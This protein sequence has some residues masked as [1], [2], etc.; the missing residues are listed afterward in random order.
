MKRR[1]V[2]YDEFAM[3]DHIERIKESAT[4]D[5]LRAKAGG[6]HG[7]AQPIF[8]VGMPRSGTTLIEQILAGHPRVKC[9][10]EIDDLRLVVDATRKSDGRP[11]PYPELLRILSPG[12]FGAI[13]AEY[14]RRLDRYAPGAD[15]IID[16]APA[17]FYLTG[18]IH[19]ALPQARIVHVTRSALDTCVSCFGKLFVGQW[20]QTY[21]L[22]ELG[23]YYRA[24]DGLMKHWR[25][26]LPA[27]A[28]LD[29]QYEAVVGD[30]EHEARRLLDYC[31]LE[32]DARVLN[33]HTREAAVTTGSAWQV[34]QPLYNAAIGRW[35]HYETH[36][37]P[38]IAELGGEQ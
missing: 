5:I 26:V 6:G 8:I 1:A 32:W 27:D 10:G 25:A 34:R 2:S 36:L 15:R 30:I 31:G 33:F 12:E 21:N 14:V 4:A 22:R 16:K 20:S 3:L 35:R 24:Y 37:A 28:F 18:L 9:A 29:V 17:N 11:A 38:L 13:G 19:L 7:S 23:R